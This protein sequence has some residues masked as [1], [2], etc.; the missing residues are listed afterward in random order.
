[1]VN[2]FGCALIPD[3]YPSDLIFIPGVPEVSNV[4]EQPGSGLIQKLFISYASL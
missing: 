1:M 2:V 3:R 4:S